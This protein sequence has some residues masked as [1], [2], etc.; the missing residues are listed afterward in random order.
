M[1]SWSLVRLRFWRSSPLFC[2]RR[3]CIFGVFG[4]CLGDEWRHF[5]RCR[6]LV[7]FLY[8]TH[9]GC[10]LS[11]ILLFVWL[12]SFRCHCR[13]GIVFWVSILVAD[14]YVVITEMLAWFFHESVDLLWGCSLGY[15]ARIRYSLNFGSG[16]VFREENVIPVFFFF[17]FRFVKAQ[18]SWVDLTRSS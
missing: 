13:W 15:V 16:I 7:H 11:G 3:R 14:L 1:C 18:A 10:L 9:T 12:V 5:L 2:C 4:S 8:R 17:F 6:S